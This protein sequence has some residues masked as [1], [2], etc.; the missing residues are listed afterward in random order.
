MSF[1]RLNYGESNKN[2][3]VKTVE[4]FCDKCKPPLFQ[5]RKKG[6]GAL[7]KYFKE[8][9]SKNFTCEPSTC[10]GCHTVFTKD[11]LVRGAP[12]FKIIGAKVV[13]K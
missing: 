10:P 4:L 8:R 5:Y 9:V 2:G 13:V 1:K 6:E 3:L 12:A 7:V 11:N